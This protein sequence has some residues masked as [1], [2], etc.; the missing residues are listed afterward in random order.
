[1]FHAV[2]LESENEVAKVLAF[3]M[4]ALR[5]GIARV[6]GATLEMTAVVEPLKDI[7]QD[8]ARE[9]YGFAVATMEGE[10]IRVMTTRDLDRMAETAR[11]ELLRI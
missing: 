4:G 3:S 7:L 11:R 6:E 2:S 10:A 5:E 8:E 1:M 9:Y